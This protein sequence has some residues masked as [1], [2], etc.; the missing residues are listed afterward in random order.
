MGELK[1]KGGWGVVKRQKRKKACE[2]IKRDVRVQTA[3]SCITVNV[4]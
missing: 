4:S 1:R 2:C 3:M